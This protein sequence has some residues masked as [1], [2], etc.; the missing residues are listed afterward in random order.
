MVRALDLAMLH[1]K[2]T[3]KLLPKFQKKVRLQ[4]P[5]FTSRFFCFVHWQGFFH[6]YI[7]LRQLHA[8]LINYD[9]GMSEAEKIHLKDRAVIEFSH[10]QE[11]QV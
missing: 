3:L 6:S 9:W 8:L 7:F 4:P 1:E 2:Q 10:H 5:Q 11:T